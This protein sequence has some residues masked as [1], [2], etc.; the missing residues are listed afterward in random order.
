MI[1]SS[2]FLEVIYIWEQVALLNSH[3][4]RDYNSYINFYLSIKHLGRKQEYFY[5]GGLEQTRRSFVLNIYIYTHTYNK[6][7]LATHTHTTKRVLLHYIPWVISS[8]VMP[9]SHHSTLN[10]IINIFRVCVY[11]EVKGCGIGGEKDWNS[12]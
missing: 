5:W 11:I 2:L 8:T 3:F 1:D 6:A 12:L 4:R 10:A 9:K 7:C